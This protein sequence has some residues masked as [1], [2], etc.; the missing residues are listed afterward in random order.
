MCCVL[1]VVCVLVCCV[2]FD[3]CVLMFVVVCLMLV[4]GVRCA[5]FVVWCFGVRCVLCVA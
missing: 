2:L 5:L 4:V 1:C 3:G